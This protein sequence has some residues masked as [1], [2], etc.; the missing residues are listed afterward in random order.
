[1]AIVADVVRAAQV[2]LAAE[3]SLAVECYFID[4]DGVYR[5]G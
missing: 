4:F 2:L 3:P 5:V 1:M